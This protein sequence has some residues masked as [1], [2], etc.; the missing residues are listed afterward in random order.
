[1]REK[2]RAMTDKELY[3]KVAN[4]SAR[5]ASL[6]LAHAPV[7]GVPVQGKA[8]IE[9]PRAER[10]MRRLGQPASALQDI[11]KKPGI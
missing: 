9:G 2:S 3:R 5:A 7:K 10:K 8:P 6:A 4:G 11:I 1:L